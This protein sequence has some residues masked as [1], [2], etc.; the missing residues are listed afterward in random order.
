VS[1]NFLAVVGTTERQTAA[2]RREAVLEAA[3]VEFARK[4]LVG[5][6][7]DAIARKAGISQP[8][9]FRLFGTKKELFIAVAEQCFADT[10]E[11]FRAAAEGKT[12]EAA[13]EAMG[14]AYID[15]ITND[16]DRLRGQLQTY[17]ACDDPE[18]CAVVRRG[19]GELVQYVRRVSGVDSERLL[20]FFA[21]GMFLN[22]IASMNLLDAPEPWAQELLQ[23]LRA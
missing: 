8:Y 1:D 2:A 18:I 19:Y 4:G 13:L 12:G 17:A 10:A 11:L 22:V 23:A 14:K 21:K 9:L 3:A 7:T 15:M 16:R 6:S 5:A 20:A